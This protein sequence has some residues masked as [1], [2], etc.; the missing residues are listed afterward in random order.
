LNFSP[1]LKTFEE[2]PPGMIGLELAPVAQDRR[3][4]SRV[5]DQFPSVTL[6][7]SIS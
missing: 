3:R 2:E 4:S 7:T 6:P 5:E 1:A